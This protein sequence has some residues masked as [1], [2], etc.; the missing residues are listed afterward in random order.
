MDRGYNF[1]PHTPP[2]NKGGTKTPIKIGLMSS[3]WKNFRAHG[4]VVKEGRMEQWLRSWDAKT[5]V[6]GFNPPLSQGSCEHSTVIAS[7]YKINIKKTN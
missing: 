4:A 7:L 3:K 2:S 1:A 5:R 6:P